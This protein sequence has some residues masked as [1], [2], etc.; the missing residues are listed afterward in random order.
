ML[1]SCNTLERPYI[2]LNGPSTNGP[3]AVPHED[4]YMCRET[5]VVKLTISQNE[6]G[7]ATGRSTTHKAHSF[8]VSSGSIKAN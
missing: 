2:S 3:R 7:G 1:A 5:R 6:D 8:L 4:Q